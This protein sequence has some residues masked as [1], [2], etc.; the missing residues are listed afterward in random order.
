MSFWTISRL[1]DIGP[2]AGYDQGKR[3][4]ISIQ[5]AGETFLHQLPAMKKKLPTAEMKDLRKLFS[6]KVLLPLL[7][8]A[9][10]APGLYIFIMIWLN[11][12]YLTAILAGLAAYGLWRFIR[13]L[14][15]P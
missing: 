1:W 15:S 10:A 4:R 3:V 13:E 2:S 6:N 12:S 5:F 14:L 7:L 11:G 9:A 8:V